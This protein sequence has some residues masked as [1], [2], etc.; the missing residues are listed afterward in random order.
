VAHLIQQELSKLLVEGLKDPRVGF[1]TITEVRLTD[2]L[3]NGVVY[4]SIIGEEAVRQ[5]SLKGLT[6]AAGFLRRELS[7]RLT[8]RF[9][10]T[11]TF[12]HDTSLDYAQR[13]DQVLRAAARGD[14]ELPAAGA[15]QP[16][17]A[18]Q[19]GREMPSMELPKPPASRKSRRP[20]RSKGPA[21]LRRGSAGREKVA[22]SP[23][24]SSRS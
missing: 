1:V 21:G 18:A 5:E 15:L 11:F 16:L 20:G 6:A 13:M 14:H 4:V 7:H 17:P 19:T 24:K 22:R 8:L 9:T 10:P 23:N 3:R 12:V 2:D